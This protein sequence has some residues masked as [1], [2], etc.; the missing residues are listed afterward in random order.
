[1]LKNQKSGFLKNN[2]SYSKPVV[3]CHLLALILIALLGLTAS[4]GNIKQLTYLQGPIDTVAFRDINFIEPTIQKGDVLS[5]TVYSDNQ[6]AS[7]LFNQGGSSAPVSSQSSGA[8][9]TAGLSGYLVGED[10][11]IR[12]YGLGLVKV[13]GITRSQL[14]NLLARQYTEKDLLQ[15]PFVETRFLNFKI[16]MVGDVNGPGVYTFPTDKVNI[17]DALA[18]AGDLTTYAKRDYLLIVREQNGTR[19]FARLDLTNPNIFNSPFFYLQQ[20]DMIVVDPHKV[21]A[22]VN[23]QTLRYISIV[24]SLVSLVA[25]FYSIFQ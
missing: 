18:M 22:T 25:I 12:L 1:M 10:G 3:S 8:T 19:S 9:P 11:N 4:C 5:I 2:R 17:F 21:K 16:T 13:E 20:N 15:N 14:S 7:S 6:L 23:D 24:T